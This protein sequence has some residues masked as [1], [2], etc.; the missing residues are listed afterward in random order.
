MAQAKMRPTTSPKSNRRSLHRTRT[1]TT[2]VVDFT[3]NGRRSSDTNTATTTTTTTKIKAAVSLSPATRSTAWMT[4]A[5]RG[6]RPL[7]RRSSVPRCSAERRRS[8]GGERRGTCR[9]S[10]PSSEPYNSSPNRAGQPTTFADR[11]R[12]YQRA[13]ATFPTAWPNNRAP[14]RRRQPIKITRHSAR[15]PAVAAVSPWKRPCHAVN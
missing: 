10:S 13:R 7:A 4:V 1:S 8:L 15:F 5:A 6:R 11:K 12:K 3:A 2:D 9:P 14:Y